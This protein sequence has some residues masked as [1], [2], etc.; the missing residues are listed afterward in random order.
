MMACTEDVSR[1]N[2]SAPQQLSVEGTGTVRYVPL[3]GGFYVIEADEGAFYDPINLGDEYKVDC[4]RISFVARLAP[5]L[6]SFHM[7]GTMVELVEIS[8]LG[9]CDTSSDQ[10]FVAEPNPT[11]VADPE[12]DNRFVRP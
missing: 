3:E 7:V 2:S 9:S 11:S 6:V 8:R 12:V 5:E 1:E 10:G 4:V